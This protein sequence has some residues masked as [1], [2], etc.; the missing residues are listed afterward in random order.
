VYFGKGIGLVEWQSS[1]KK[2]HFRLEQIL[3][4]EEW[5]KIISR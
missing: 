1:N 4:Q 5:L 3:S 2:L